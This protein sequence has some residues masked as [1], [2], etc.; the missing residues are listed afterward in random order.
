MS[1]AKRF[2]T[3]ALLAIVFGFAMSAAIAWGIL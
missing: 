3:V 2:A 1:N